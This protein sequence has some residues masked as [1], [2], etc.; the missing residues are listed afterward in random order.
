MVA[1]MG[2][3]RC[4]NG[5]QQWQRHNPDGHQWWW[6]NGWQDDS[7]SATA[8]A[9]NG[10]SSKEGNGNGNGNGNEG[11]RQAKAMAT[12]RAMAWQ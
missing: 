5:S 7:N 4:H 2:D 12:K 10:N 11:D 8:I 9:M 3:N 1:A 6:C